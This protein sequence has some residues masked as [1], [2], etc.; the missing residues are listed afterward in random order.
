[1]TVGAVTT[2]NDYLAHADECEG[3]AGQ[4]KLAAVKQSFLAS[5]AMWRRMAADPAWDEGV[6]FQP[7]LGQ[8]SK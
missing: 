5:A 4:A 1:L 2:R 6:Q 3:L 8:T 7:I